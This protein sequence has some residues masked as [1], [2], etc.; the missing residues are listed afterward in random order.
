[1]HIARDIVLALPA[2]CKHPNVVGLDALRLHRSLTAPWADVSARGQCLARGVLKQCAHTWAAGTLSCIYAEG[3][4]ICACNQTMA[5]A[6][7]QY[8]SVHAE[9][10]SIVTGSQ[11]LTSGVAATASFLVPVA[12]V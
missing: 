7:C 1:M 6:P 10:H 4:N 12:P 3:H 2:S 8:P 5:N 11:Y 9:A